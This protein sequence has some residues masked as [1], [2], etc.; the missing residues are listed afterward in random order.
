MKFNCSTQNITT[1]NGSGRWGQLSQRITVLE[2]KVETIIEKLGED[3]CRSSPC[4]NGGTCMDLYDS[5]VCHCPSEWDG[6]T[7]S[8]DVNECIILSGS[9]S[10]CQN[11]GT[12]QNTRGGYM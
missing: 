10:G 5:F 2:A 1:E 9:D 6:P 8:N 11:G 3:N 4:E 12:C 7:C